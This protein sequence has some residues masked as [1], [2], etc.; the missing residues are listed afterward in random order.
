ME[1]L[2]EYKRTYAFGMDYGTSHFKFGPI[3]SGE[4]PEITEN[5]GYF[6]DKDSIMLKTFEVPKSVIVGND[7]PLY[8]Q[9]SE[10]LSSRLIYPM[11]NGMIEKNDVNAWKVVKEISRYG[12]SAFKPTNKDF[13]G[14]Y[15]IASLS[16][17]SPKYMYEKLFQIY[18]EIRKDDKSI[19]AATIIPQPLAVAIAHKETTC[20]VVESGHG[21]TQV[22]P[23]SRYPI[24]N[25]IIA[26]NRGGGDANG[27][28][29]EILKDIGYGDLAQQ[30]SF[31]RKVKESIGLIPIDLDKAIYKAKQDPK[32]FNTK[33][34]IPGTRIMI[35]LDENT[36]IRFL[37]GEYV[38]NPTHETFNS[39][40]SRGM[41]KPKDVKI[42]DTTFRGMI[43]FG[44]AI[45][46]AVEKCPI[47]LQPYLYRQVLLSGGN[48]NWVAPAELD[49]IATDSATKIRALLKGHG[50]TNVKIRM[51][52]DPQYSVWR[53]CVIYGYA[54]PEDY[55]WNWERMEGW[56][57]FNE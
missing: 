8:L 54:V 12:F 16:S 34:K 5:R 14:F 9:S 21:N 43:D 52:Q 49:G 32:K 42:G 1:E 23:I 17:I 25:A 31:I 22:C 35:D 29:S 11:R 48:F 56:F 24:R 41:S 6:P 19:M 10:D 57:M 39:Y 46:E 36:W 2:E 15:L 28:T 37:I 51:T 18:E 3:S 7:I 33:F 44:E 50:I 40:F 47:E 27:L 13:N 20:V 30:E 45:V 38:F 53:G 4:I 26:I 55:T